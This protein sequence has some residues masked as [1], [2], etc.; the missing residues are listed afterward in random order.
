MN[1]FLHWCKCEKL[2]LML[3]MLGGSMRSSS[4]GTTPSNPGL[5]SSIALSDRITS[6]RGFLETN[7]H[8]NL[9]QILLIL[10]AFQHL[11]EHFGRVMAIHRLEEALAI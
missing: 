11:P 3:S 6:C 1:T 9:T 8:K 2:A 4:S 10:K 5:S 7:K